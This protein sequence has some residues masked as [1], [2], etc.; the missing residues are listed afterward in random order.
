MF[1][2]KLTP[3]SILIFFSVS[4]VVCFI[5]LKVQ[6]WERK[7]PWHDQL[8]GRQEQLDELNVQDQCGMHLDWID[9]I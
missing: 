1:F 8:D 6:E 2:Y 4:V 5:T 7:N 3:P 9:P